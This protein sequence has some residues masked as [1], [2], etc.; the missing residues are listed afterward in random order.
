MTG[1]GPSSGDPTGGDAPFQ[2]Y[3]SARPTA[4]HATRTLRFLF[5]GK[6]VTFT[7][8]RGVF[9][10]EQVDPGTALLIENLELRGDERLL[11][12]GCGWGAIGIAAALSLPHGSATLVDLNHRAVQLAR[13]N[14]RV[15]HVTNAQVLKGDLYEP[16]QG[17]RYDVIATNPAFK[18]G[19]EL[20]LRSLSEAKDHLVPGGR[21][22]MVGK[23]SQ[24]V[25]FYQRWLQEHWGKV[26]VLAR[27]SGYRLLEASDPAPTSTSA[28]R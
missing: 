19:R 12:L 16:V 5:R 8:D 2:H 27:R 26:E 3:F 20:V 13:E 17:E 1:Q 7:T 22:V 23:G 18:A 4:P 15:N 21:L 9:S 24:G 10:Y 6:V 28:E 25:I 14:V 11:D